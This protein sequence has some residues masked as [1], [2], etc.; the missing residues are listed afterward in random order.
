MSCL[1]C[2]LLKRLALAPARTLAR[3]HSD[4]LNGV[5]LATRVSDVRKGLLGIGLC[6]ASVGGGHA[7]IFLLRLN[8]D[9]GS[10]LRRRRFPRLRP[11]LLSKQTTAL[12][13][14]PPNQSYT[15]PLASTAV[16]ALAPTCSRMEPAPG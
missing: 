2:P 8:L 11:L 4:W 16:R 7:C 15:L 14:E 6:A 13:H 12:S 3:T 9:S 10:A 1:V 5:K